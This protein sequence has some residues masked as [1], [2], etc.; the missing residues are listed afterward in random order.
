LLALFALACRR[1]L[2]GVE[3]PDFQIFCK[4]AKLG[5]IRS[6]KKICRKVLIRK[7]NRAGQNVSLAQNWLDLMAIGFAEKKTITQKI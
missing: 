4:N 1:S 2:V 5:R 3:A 6:N 7:D